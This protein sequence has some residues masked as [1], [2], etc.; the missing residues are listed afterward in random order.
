MGLG[1]CIIPETRSRYSA[2][3]VLSAILRAPCKKEGIG[4]VLSMSLF[5]MVC[6]GM[7]MVFATDKIGRA[8]CPGKTDSRYAMLGDIVAELAKKVWMFNFLSPRKINSWCAQ[9]PSARNANSHKC[10]VIL[11]AW[12]GWVVLRGSAKCSRHAACATQE[13][14][15]VGDKGILRDSPKKS[16][17]F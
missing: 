2:T 15:D 6:C 10:G 11:P 8:A 1:G 7:P 9:Q 14:P 4:K 12:A 17:P 13:S 3:S 5:L 16:S